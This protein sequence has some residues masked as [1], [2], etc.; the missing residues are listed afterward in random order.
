MATDFR[1]TQYV[2]AAHVRNPQENPPPAGVEA[3][4]LAIYRDLFYNNVEGFLRGFFPVLHSLYA[5]TDWQALVRAFLANHRA[6]SPY[7][8]EIAEEFL[9][10]LQCSHA[11]RPCDPPFMLELA[12]Y[13]W[14][15]LVVDVA[16]CDPVP[17]DLDPHGDLMASPPVPSSTAVL[18]M[19]HWPVHQISRDFRPTGPA[20]DPVW[21]LVYRDEADAV[22]F[23]VLNAA[24]A[25][26]WSLMQ[27]DP[28]VTGT[29]LAADV[30]RES[31]HADGSVV[32]EGAAGMLAMWR[33][34]GL[35]LGVRA[36]RGK[37]G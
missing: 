29:Q 11:P 21:L 24:S 34:R 31:G 27:S 5:D 26:L 8:L 7:F 33:A 10:W 35:V 3:R 17:D 37:T 14:L 19:Y 28:S 23:M 12:H 16:E 2:F 15:E 36:G 4:R 22:R 25:R 32:R 30:A 13:E 18:G 9:G 20:A 6:R 1:A